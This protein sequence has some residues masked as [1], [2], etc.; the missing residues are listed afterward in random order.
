[1]GADAP[2]HNDDGPEAGSEPP[3]PGGHEGR[4]PLRGA[5]VEAD[6][7]YADDGAHQQYPVYGIEQR[8]GLAHRLVHLQAE[9]RARP[10][11]AD[12]AEGGPDVRAG[13]ALDGHHVG[14]GVDKATEPIVGV[15]D[16]EMDVERLVRAPTQSGHDVRAKEQFGGIVPVE[17][18]DV[19]GIGHLGHAVHG[20]TQRQQVG[21][22]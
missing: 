3:C 6:A 2:V 8:L 18:V 22:P 7:L 12:L 15:G 1:M 4:D 16:V 11:G 17:H 10:P 5:R 21:G 13:P 19:E 14:A 9:R 20:L